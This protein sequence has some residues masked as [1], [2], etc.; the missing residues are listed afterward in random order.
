MLPQALRRS[1]GA[2]RAIVFGIQVTSA[3][4]IGIDAYVLDSL[5]PD[6]SVTI[7]GPASL[8]VYLCLWRKTRGGARP[9]VLSLQ[10]LVDGTGLAKRSVQMALE[11][12]QRRELV[13][14]SR[15]SATSAPS[16]TLRCYWR[17]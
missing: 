13:T 3:E 2:T 11:H 8:I 7:G 10:M 9:A 4:R 6:W 15:A 12:L 16:W 17:K 1:S 14:A 5:M